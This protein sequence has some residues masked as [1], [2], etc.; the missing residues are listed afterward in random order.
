MIWN[1]L[2]SDDKSTD[3]EIGQR[4][5]AVFGDGGGAEFFQRTGEH[6][7]VDADG[8]EIDESHIFEFFDLWLPL[9]E[10]MKLWFE[11]EFCTCAE[12]E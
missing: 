8:E 7:Y 12:Q 4:F 10:G 6:E 9:P 2:S 3:P 11:N 1:K 5:C